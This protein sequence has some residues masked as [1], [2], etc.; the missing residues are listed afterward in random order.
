MTLLTVTVC[1]AALIERAAKTLSHKSTVGTTELPF[2]LDN[3][4]V[5]VLFVEL[6]PEVSQAADP[7]LPATSQ[8]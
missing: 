7:K 2:S 3:C 1:L 5:G 8:L 6:L 4:P